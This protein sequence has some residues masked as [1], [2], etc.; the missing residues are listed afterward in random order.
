MEK[1]TSGGVGSPFVTIDKG[2]VA[3]N[4]FRIGSDQQKQIDRSVGLVIFST[5][6]RRLQQL[7]ITDAETATM[8][9]NGSFVNVKHLRFTKP[10]PRKDDPR[11]H[12]NFHE[13][14][15][16]LRVSLWII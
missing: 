1:Q 8:A 13:E 3:R 12:T 9:S 4:F 6:K 5:S 14:K 2:M 16:T 7:F 11:R 10:I 15:L